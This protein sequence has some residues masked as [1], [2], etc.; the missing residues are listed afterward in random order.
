MKGVRFDSAHS[1]YPRLDLEWSLHSRF[2]IHYSATKAYKMGRN[3]LMGNF[4]GFD[5]FGKV[6]ELRG[7][8]S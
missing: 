5:A 3:G 1:R 2:L 6:G 7:G 8:R 4:Q